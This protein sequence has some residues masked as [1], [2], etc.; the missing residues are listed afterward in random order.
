MFQSVFQLPTHLLI[1]SDVV[2]IT[3]PF[4][5]DGRTSVERGERVKYIHVV[6]LFILIYMTGHYP[7]KRNSY[8]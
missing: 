1:E 3:G 4:Q 7:L 6:K 2:V 8:T 5:P